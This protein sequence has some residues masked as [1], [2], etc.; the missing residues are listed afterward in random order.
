MK[1]ADDH[2][3][4]C[5]NKPHYLSKIDKLYSLIKKSF[6]KTTQKNTCT[7]INLA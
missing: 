1:K 4:S 6:A 3:P 5:E 2:L 7:L